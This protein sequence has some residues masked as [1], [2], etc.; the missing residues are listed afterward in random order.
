MGI[1]LDSADGMEVSTFPA[2]G[3]A[4][5]TAFGYNGGEFRHSAAA[6]EPDWDIQGYLFKMAS[7]QRRTV[8]WKRDLKDVCGGLREDESGRCIKCNDWG[9]KW[10]AL[11]LI[12]N[13]YDEWGLETGTQARNVIR[14]QL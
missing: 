1:H 9:R 14:D 13:S 3:T 11:T 5:P 4:T 2:C 7:C 8:E 6:G 10:R 12:T